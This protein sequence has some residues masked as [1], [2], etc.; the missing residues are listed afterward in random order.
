MD[1]RPHLDSE[2]RQW[3]GDSRVLAPLAVESG[4]RSV[5]VR[6]RQRRQR[7]SASF[8]EL[9]GHGN[10]HDRHKNPERETARR[11]DVPP[12]HSRAH[13]PGLHRWRPGLSPELQRAMRSYEVVMT[14]QELN[15]PAELVFASG[16]ARRATVQVRRALTN[17]KVQAL[18]ERRVQVLGILRLQQRVLQPRR[19]T[20]LHAPLDADDTI[21]PPRLITVGGG[22][23]GAGLA[24]GLAERGVKVLVLERETLDIRRA[25][26]EE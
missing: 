26:G 3:I 19:G 23:A 6:P 20:D 22:L 4:R 1:G 11:E 13:Q 12:V 24:K 10:A 21:V 16:V 2:V 14:T 25:G 17:G 7:G 5:F 15:V 18:D 9:D 8:Y